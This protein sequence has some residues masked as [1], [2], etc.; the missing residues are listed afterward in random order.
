MFESYWKR[1]IKN[2]YQNMENNSL[3]NKDLDS[4]FAC[5]DNDKYRKTKIK[6]YKD[7]TNWN[8]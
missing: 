4:E 8:F 6:S 7:K 3:I 5:V 1:A 2:L